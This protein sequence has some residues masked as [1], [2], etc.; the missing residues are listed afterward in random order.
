VL[1]KQEIFTRVADHLLT[2]FDKSISSDSLFC[3]YRAPDGKKCAIGCLITDAAYSPEL[4]G[5]LVWRSAVRNALLL[6]GVRDADT[7]IMQM[8]VELQT[9]HDCTEP[10][11]W[12][13][14][15]DKICKTHELTYTVSEEA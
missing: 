2:Q 15:L 8:L 14:G 9:L 11:R 10:Q 7:S 1:T 4:E 3:A 13:E 12:I 6:S 5:A